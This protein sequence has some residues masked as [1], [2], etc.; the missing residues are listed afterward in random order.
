VI[1]ETFIDFRGKDG[2]PLP[3]RIGEAGRLA[4]ALIRT[5][6]EAGYLSVEPLGQ[7]SK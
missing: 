1:L 6:R 3:I 4:D 5:V 2:D 7:I